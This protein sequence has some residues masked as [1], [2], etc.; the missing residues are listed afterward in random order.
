MWRVENTG[1]MPTRCG[2]WA[3]LLDGVE[4]LNGPA[5]VTLAAG[6]RKKNERFNGKRDVRKSSWRRLFRRSPADGRFARMT[7]RPAIPLLALLLSACFVFN[8]GKKA[9]PAPAVDVPEGEIALNVTNHNYLDVVVYVLHD[10][11]QTRVG[12][13]TGSSSSLF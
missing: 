9:A 13:A 2:A 6:T 10:G 11:L 3:T 7:R 5:K 4:Q 12:T 8:R 1:D